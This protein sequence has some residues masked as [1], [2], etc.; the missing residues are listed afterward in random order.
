VLF[1]GNLPEPIPSLPQD[2]D[3]SQYTLLS[4]QISFLNQFQETPAMNRR[5]TAINSICMGSHDVSRK[6]A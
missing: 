4:I 1:S 3:Y 2:N 6:E 5:S